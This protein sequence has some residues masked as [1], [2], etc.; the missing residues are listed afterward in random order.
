MSYNYPE[1]RLDEMDAVRA[2]N[3]ESTKM[4]VY[5]FRWKDSTSFQNDQRAWLATGI[6]SM[7]ALG[8]TVLWITDGSPVDCEITHWPDDNSVMPEHAKSSDW[9]C[10]NAGRFTRMAGGPDQMEFDPFG[11]KGEGQW[12]EAGAHECGHFVNL[13]HFTGKFPSVMSPT[14]AVGTEFAKDLS[15]GEQLKGSGAPKGPTRVDFEAFDAVVK[16]GLLP[17]PVVA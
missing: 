2:Q 9:R 1:S 13:Q 8:F 6:A 14:L 4:P 11:L 5:R 7:Q 10:K 15:A 3:G 12:I 16:H 17:I